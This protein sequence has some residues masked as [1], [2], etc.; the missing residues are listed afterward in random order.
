MSTSVCLSLSLGHTRATS[1]SIHCHFR[2]TEPNMSGTTPASFLPKDTLK[3]EKFEGRRTDR[4]ACDA[5]V[6]RAERSFRLLQITDTDTKLSFAS[7]SLPATSPAGQWF[8]SQQTSASTE[9]TTWATFKTRFAKRF[10]LTAADVDQI[11]QSFLVAKQNSG[12]VSDFVQY[13]D[14]TRDKLATR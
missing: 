2:E 12:T 4:S 10:G 13:V 8:D 14:S 5:W 11:E 6:N 7:A 1:N 9:I 3:L